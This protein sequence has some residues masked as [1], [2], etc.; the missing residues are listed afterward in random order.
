MDRRQFIAGAGGALA[1]AE[2]DRSLAEMASNNAVALETLAKDPA[3]QLRKL[4]D[5]ILQSLGK[6]SGEILA[7]TSR[8][9]DLARRVY[10]SFMRFRRAAVR[11]GEI[12][13]QSYLNARALMFPFGG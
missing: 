12:S 13:E 9:D 11:W 2:N 5:S 3:I 8:I 4:D 1:A 10:E 7:E 6:F